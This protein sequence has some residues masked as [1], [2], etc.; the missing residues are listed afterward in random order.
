MRISVLGE[1]GERFSENY[2]LPIGS[3][4]FANSDIIDMMVVAR[5]QNMLSFFARFEADRESMV[6]YL[7]NHAELDHNR[8][9]FLICSKDKILGHCG[10][11]K[12]SEKQF[13]IDNVM[14]LDEQSP[15]IVY[16]ALYTL[17]MWNRNLYPK[18]DYILKVIS[19]NES[20]LNLYSKL[21]FVEKERRQLVKKIISDTRYELVEN[22]SSSSGSDEEMIIMS[23]DYI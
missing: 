22:E 13:E 20:A 3:W 18:C 6:S 11:R 4:I 12:I 2:L 17:I 8:L 23:L 21:N 7:K 10:L 16:A 5:Q 1:L 14:R 19:S 15:G 9:L